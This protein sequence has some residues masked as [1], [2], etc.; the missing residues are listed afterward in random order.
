[1]L[2][3]RWKICSRDG[4]PAGLGGQGEVL[5]QFRSTPEGTDLK[6]PGCSEGVE[7]V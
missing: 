1:M 2:C 4:N 5:F 3:E 7:E 6:T